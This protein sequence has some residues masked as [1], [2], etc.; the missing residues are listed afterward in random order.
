MCDAP[1][2]KLRLYCIRYG[3]LIVI[4]GGPKKARKFQE[5]KKLKDENFFLRKLPAGITKRIRNNEIW[6]SEN[7]MEF[8]G[9]LTFNDQEDE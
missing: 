6:Y 9:N 3:A 1:G 5:D 2:K 7:Y 8:E 4:I